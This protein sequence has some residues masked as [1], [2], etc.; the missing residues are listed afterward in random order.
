M[1]LEVRQLVHSYREG[2]RIHPVLT[3][4]NLQ[5]Q[6]GEFLALLGRSGSGKSTLLN[7]MAGIDLPDSG[8]IL[9]RGKNLTQL[10]ERERTLFRRQH[11]GFVYQFFNLI[12]TLTAAENIAL[13]LELNGHAETEI[14]KRVTQLLQQVEL[15]DRAQAF[16][17]RLSGGEQQRIAIARALAHRPALILADEPTGNLDAIT[18][19]SVLQLLTQLVRGAGQ[20]LVMVTH[21]HAVTNAA[22]RVATLQRGVIEH[23]IRSDD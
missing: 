9:I 11:I 4:L 21:S 19:S 6:E 18:G 12:P 8:E 22:N 23:T 15:E 5:V 17:D 10:S 13:P 2:G 16:P 20:T 3:G 1:T 14:R 7:L